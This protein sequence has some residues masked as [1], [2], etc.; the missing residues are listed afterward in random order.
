[1]KTNVYKRFDPQVMESEERIG[2]NRGLPTTT[3]LTLNNNPSI[4]I[5]S[6]NLNH[7]SSFL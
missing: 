1:M 2:I 4:M 6:Q 5:A 7:S 3:D